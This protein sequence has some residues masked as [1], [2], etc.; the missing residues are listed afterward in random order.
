M[1]FI[2]SLVGWVGL[3]L[4]I[5]GEI[6]G[7]GVPNA[8]IRYHLQTGRSSTD[9]GGDIPAV[10]LR[11]TSDRPLGAFTNPFRSDK[12]GIDQYF[13]TDIETSQPSELRSLVFESQWTD[14]DMS[15]RQKRSG[16][17]NDGICIAYLSWTPEASMYNSEY[18]RGAI[19]G[20]FFYFCGFDWYYSGKVKEFEGQTAQLRCGW[21]DGDNSSGN[22]ASSI[23]IDTDLVGRGF[24]EKN[25]KNLPQIQSLC[26]Q[27]LNFARTVLPQ[28]IS[29]RKTYK[30]KAYITGG[31]GAI[32]LC[33]SPTSWGPSML[34]MKEK[35]FCD[36]ETKTKV[37]LCGGNTVSGCVQYDRV[38]GKPNNS[39][40]HAPP[41][42]YLIPV[43]FTNGEIKPTVYKLEYFTL[44][45]TNGTVL[46]DGADV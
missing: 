17:L 43:N 16:P 26:G 23:D 33:D 25:A 31:E 40:S 35:I 18:R 22:S 37:P 41:E 12:A 42:R 21:M 6:S 19:I 15:T 24:L 34:S 32:T 38:Q 39:G 4:A 28:K 2:D 29:I 11:D 36:M 27:G 30:N 5:G 14:Y 45:Y 13:N 20:D 7:T 10:W 1:I 9:S 44:L 46:D 3:I 8:K